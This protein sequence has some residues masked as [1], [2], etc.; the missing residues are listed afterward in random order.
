M[1]ATEALELPTDVPGHVRPFLTKQLKCQS[2]Q[3]STRH[4]QEC[5]A[6]LAY[7]L[8]RHRSAADMRAEQPNCDVEAEYSPILRQFPNQPR[9]P[10]KA[11]AAPPDI[12]REV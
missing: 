4:P 9:P 5:P 11:T 1:Q 12:R 8:M 3:R 7:F 2:L 6:S 10:I